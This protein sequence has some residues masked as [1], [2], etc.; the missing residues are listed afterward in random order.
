MSATSLNVV[1]DSV[2]MLNDSNQLDVLTRELSASTLSTPHYVDSAN[3][4]AVDSCA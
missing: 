3:W 2:E 4:A 1:V